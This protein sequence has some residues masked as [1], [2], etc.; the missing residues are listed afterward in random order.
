MGV[1]PGVFLRPMEPSVKRTIER[2]TGRSFAHD[3]V[4][5]Q[6]PV[7]TRRETGRAGAVEPPSRTADPVSRTSDPG[8]RAAPIAV[9]AG[10]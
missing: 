4:T 8:L 9:R 2:V 5:V 10:K 7:V 1:F 6:P 3:A